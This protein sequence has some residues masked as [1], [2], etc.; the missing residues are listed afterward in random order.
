LTYFVPEDATDR[1]LCKITIKFSK[2]GTLVV[3]TAESDQGCGF[4]LNVSANGTYRKTSG[5]KPKFGKNPLQQ[6]GASSVE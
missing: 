6:K 1:E 3:T 4:G 2:P 5:A